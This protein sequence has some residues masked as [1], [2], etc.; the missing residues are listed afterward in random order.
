M[1]DTKV[2]RAVRKFSQ[3]MTR[4]ED[5]QARLRAREKRN[6][7][8]RHYRLGLVLEGFLF[9]EPALLARVEE[10]IRQEEPRVRAAFA[11]DRPPSWFEKPRRDDPKKVVDTRRFWLGAV[12]ERMLTGDG[13]LLARIEALMQ[14]QAPHVRSVF[15]MDGYG[16]SWLDQRPRADRS[17]R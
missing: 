7:A 11:L 13:P 3:A 4:L 2:A 6:E 10:L 8:T 1:T 15:G 5:A 16:P 9:E 14:A 12:L 17:V